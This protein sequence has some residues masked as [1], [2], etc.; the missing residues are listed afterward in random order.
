LGLSAVD[1]SL[2]LFF[3]LI[4]YNKNSSREARVFVVQRPKLLGE[5]GL[6][7]PAEG[8]SEENHSKGKEDGKEDLEGILTR[9]SRRKSWDKG[10]PEYLRSSW[11]TSHNCCDERCWSTIKG[12]WRSHA[13]K[14]RDVIIVGVR[15]VV[16]RGT[17]IRDII[18]IR[19]AASA[20]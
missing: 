11:L 19:S 18:V 7:L 9:A 16:A 4:I 17:A 6:F 8:E 3:R 20:A 10:S 5:I 12:E 15:A 13:D 14:G 2:L 1:G